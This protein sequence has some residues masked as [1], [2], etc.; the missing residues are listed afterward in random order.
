MSQYLT[1]DIEVQT[2]THLARKYPVETVDI[3]H[4]LEVAPESKEL[5]FQV[6]PAPIC[7]H[8]KNQKGEHLIF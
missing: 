8:Y 1:R 2:L 7:A 5:L 6:C 4:H 3:V